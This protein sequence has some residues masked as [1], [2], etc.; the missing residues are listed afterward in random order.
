M[1][2]ISKKQSEINRKLGKVYMEIMDEQFELFAKKYAG[3]KPP[4]RG[5]MPDFGSYGR[6]IFV[7]V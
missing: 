3:S 5:W 7:V 1:K 2:A 4:V 6:R